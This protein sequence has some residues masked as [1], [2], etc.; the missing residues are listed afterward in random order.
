[1][2]SRSIENA[3]R[4]IEGRNFGIRKHVL[5]YDDVMNKQ[6]E[7]MYAERMKVIKADCV[8]QDI[9]NLIPDFVHYVVS[10]CVPSENKPD[11]WD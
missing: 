4:T 11:T 10:S 1:M 6:R 9:L 2:L 5:Q 3:Q 7:V 8:H